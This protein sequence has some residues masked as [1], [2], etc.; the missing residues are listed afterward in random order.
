M[1]YSEQK[2]SISLEDTQQQKYALKAPIVTL[3][4]G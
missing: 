1:Q 4:Y 2:C 3:G